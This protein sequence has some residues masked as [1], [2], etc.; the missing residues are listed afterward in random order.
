[1]LKKFLS[2]FLICIL[3]LVTIC[4]KSP[5]SV[6]VSKKS[7]DAEES[8]IKWVDFN[9]SYEALSDAMELDIETYEQ[10]LHI[11]W[12]STLAYLATRYGGGFSA[13]QKQDLTDLQDKLNQGE[14]MEALTRNMK[15]YDYYYKAYD[16]VIGDFLG[17]DKN[18]V[19]GLA[20]YSPI[21]EGYWYTDSDDF[22]NGRS[23]G[24]ARKHLGHD[25][26]SSVGTPVVSV[27]DGTVEALGWNQYGGW[28]IGIRSND[29]QR[30]YY[31]AH[32]RKDAPYTK[33]LKIGSKVSAGQII[34]FSGQTGYSIKENV[35][36]INVPHLH[37]GMQLIFDES[38]K[39]CNSEIWI[40]TYPLIRLLSK[41]RAS[42]KSKPEKNDTVPAA[43]A[44]SEKDTA[45]VPILMYHGLTKDPARVNDYF[46]PAETFEEDIKYLSAQGYTAVTMEELIDFVY[47]KT[48]RIKLPKNPV[49]ISFDDG[50]Y[51]NWQYASPV[52]KRYGMKA[53]IS[54]IGQPAAEASETPYKNPSSCSVT[55]EQMRQMKD[56]GLWE[57][58][59]H[60][61][62]LHS[63]NNG[64][65]GAAKKT[66][67]S[68]Q[69][70]ETML[71]KDLTAL[72]NTLKKELGAPPQVFTWPFGAYNSDAE[73]MLKSMGFK[74]T[75]GCRSGINT[76]KKGDTECL[77]MLKR[78]LR[79]PG[80]S[81]ESCL[82]E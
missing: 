67:E 23:Y 44:L 7:G 16:A 61:Y 54:V 10:D 79:S 40:D 38:Q 53:V 80:V 58:Q 59:N 76:I 2:L 73:V 46:L 26:F 57:I 43:A 1:M 50:F 27:E 29:G 48:G 6:P 75:L 14:S 13:Y 78:N 18:G 31:Y 33:G 17:L 60:T 55:W 49:V 30:Y 68:Q 72:Q 45:Q 69:A 8:P 11:G 74:A 20:A 36:N 56:S 15:Y 77:Y 65:K 39:E 42:P 66:E 70:Y 81:L 24:F 62:N 9:V 64:R 19:Y 22:G 82:T 3:V 25:L 4:E 37:F 32:L 71:K 47:D 5:G 51:N 63:L 34:G 21:A 28:R 52:L 41:H 12:V 35:N